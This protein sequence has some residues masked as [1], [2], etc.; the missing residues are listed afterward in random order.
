MKQTSGRALMTHCVTEI[1][2]SD[3]T[4]KSPAPS[5]RGEV[6]SAA[7]SMPAFTP[8]SAGVA[9]HSQYESGGGRE[10]VGA[11]SGP[12]W[13]GS[14]IQSPR[15]QM[16]SLRDIKK[17]ERNS[18]LSLCRRRGPSDS[19]NDR[20]IDDGSELSGTGGGGRGAGVFGCDGGLIRPADGIGTSG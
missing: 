17:E 15:W 11:S 1:P 6:L 13:R 2:R 14:F 4:L 9:L 5:Q 20:A 19:E 10:T 7:G 3:I 12:A 16:G 18:P 8:S